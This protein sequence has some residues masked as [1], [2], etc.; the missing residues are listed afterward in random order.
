M[1]FQSDC[2]CIIGMQVIESVPSTPR[3]LPQ[4]AF[5]PYP[6][7]LLWQPQ[8]GSRVVFLP[9]FDQGACLVHAFV[10]VCN[11]CVPYGS[12]FLCGGLCLL[13][14]VY[15]SPLVKFVYF[16]LAVVK[17]SGCCSTSF[18]KYMCIALRHTFR[19]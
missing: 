1:N 16:F 10:S 6:P 7:A 17:C 5:H 9:V 2:P 18:G 15:S 3:N 4:A 19:S 11:R 12:D 13:T 8:L 14:V